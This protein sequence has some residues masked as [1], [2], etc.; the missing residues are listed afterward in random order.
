MQSDNPVSKIA[1]HGGKEISSMA[2]QRCERCELGIVK[3]SDKFNFAVPAKNRIDKLDN[4]RALKAAYETAK[5]PI[6]AGKMT[7]AKT[8]EAG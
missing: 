5:C 6:C 4:Q 7:S 8:A 2:V 3:H 1:L